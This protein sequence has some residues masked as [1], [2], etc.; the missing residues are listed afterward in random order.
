MKW[1]RHSMTSALIVLLLAS[2]AAGIFLRPIYIPAER[3]LENA[4]AYVQ[5]HPE[6]ASGYYILGRIHYLVFVNKSFLVLAFPAP[7]GDPREPVPHWWEEDYL[8]QIRFDE[9]TRVALEEY[10]YKSTAEVSEEESEAFWARVEEI[11]MMLENKGWMPEPPAEEQL[12]A[13][14]GLARWYFDKAIALDPNNALYYLGQASLGEQYLEYLAET[15]RPAIPPA[16][17]TITLDS[18]KALYLRAYNLAI[19]EDLARATL[20]VEGLAGIISYEAGRAYVRLW[21]AEDQIPP[22]V[23]EQIERI[24]ANLAILEA[25]PPGPITPIVFSLEPHASLA[26]LLAPQRTVHFDLDGNGSAER[27]SWLKP[28]T[29]LLV[30]DADRDGQIT[31]GRELFGSVTWW[32]FFPDG[33]RALDVLDN[34]RDGYLSGAELDGIGVWFDRNTNGQSDEGEVTP[35]SDAGIAGIGVRPTGR[36]GR[37]LA[38][39]AG[40]RLKDGRTVPSYDWIAPAGK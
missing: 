17:R 36:D 16:L 2:L 12:V 26:D 19:D 25:L 9:A 21:Q 14:A 5:E 6:D 10:G 23:Q 7:E 18:V 31:S 8:R 22:Q 35:V 38:H 32:L 30:W 20:P 40:I 37:A 4:K 33:Y 34:N 11:R 24:E 39:R 1:F 29:G 27:R 15:T 28:T 13:H 3:L